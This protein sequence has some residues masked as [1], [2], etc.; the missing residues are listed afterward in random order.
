LKVA[1]DENVPAAMV[2]LFRILAEEQ[3]LKSLTAGLIIEAAIDHTPKPGDRDYLRRNDVPWLTR[4]ANSGGKVV[5]SGNTAMKKQPHERLALVQLGLVT[6]FFEPQWSN[7]PFF[8]KCSLLLNWWPE[9][10]RVSKAAKPGTF[11]HIPCDWGDGRTL[12]Q[13]ENEDMRL[14]KI[15]RQLAQRDMIRAKRAAARAATPGQLPLNLEGA[16][17]EPE[18]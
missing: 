10:A 6:I 2:R 17:S 1:F 7:W 11:W 5:I 4:F 9:I 14:V 3:R 18:K 12:R 15:Q 8:R 16:A 13:V